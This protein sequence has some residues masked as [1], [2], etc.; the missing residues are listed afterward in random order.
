MTADPRRERFEELLAA[1]ATQGLTAAEERELVALLSTFYDEDQE[2]FQLAAAA[3]HLALDPHPEPLPPELAEKLRRTAPTPASAEPSGAPAN[4]PTRRSRAVWAGWVVAAGLAGVLVYTNWPKPTPPVE[5]QPE[6]VR[7]YELGLRDAGGGGLPIQ[8]SEW[9]RRLLADPAAKAAT[10]V[11]DGQKPVTGN[12]VWSDAKQEG[13]LEVRG[14]PPIDPME[15]TYQL[16]IVDGGRTDPDHKQPVDGGVFRVSSDGTALVTVRAPIRVK[17][18]TLFAITKEK[19][20]AGVV[21]SK[22]GAAGEF[23]LV[24]APKQG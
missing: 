12:V 16:W 14:L 22:K 17:N 19:D 10:F 3:V 9:R 21:V 5:N 8:P 11:A 6:W 15:G 7:A 23:E 24:L 18:A 2:A 20:P 4:P 13:Y 1:E